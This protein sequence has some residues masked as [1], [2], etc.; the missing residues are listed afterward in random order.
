M[1]KVV[2]TNESLSTLNVLNPPSKG[3]L[4]LTSWDV[5]QQVCFDSDNE[6]VLMYL[7]SLKVLTSVKVRMPQYLLQ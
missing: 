7:L 1:E 2:A 5:P 3:T 4:Q 6:E